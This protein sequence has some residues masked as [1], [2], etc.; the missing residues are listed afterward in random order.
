MKHPSSSLL[1]F[2]LAFGFAATVRAAGIFPGSTDF[3]DM[4]VGALPSD[5]FFA[6]NTADSSIVSNAAVAAQIAAADR[7]ANFDYA[8]TRDKVLSVDATTNAPLVRTLAANGG[9][10][11]LTDSNGNPS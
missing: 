1:S 5:G 10:P 3:E 11:Q 7:P 9:D 6:G 2:A 8:D 4:S